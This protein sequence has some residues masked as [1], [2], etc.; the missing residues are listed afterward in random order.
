MGSEAVGEIRRAAVLGAG[1]MGAQIAAHL[2]NAGVPVW[3][4]D[5][6]AKDGDRTGIARRAIDGLAKLDPAPLAA[7]GLA[8]HIGAANYDEHL[9]R[10]AE[11]DLVIEAIA[12]RL[13]WKRELFARIA[14]HLAPHAILASNTSGLSISALAAGLPDELQSRFCGIHFFNP[15][16]YMH[17]VELIPAPASAPA[18]LDALETFLTTALGKG[19]IRAKDTPNFIANRIGVFSILA[20]F[21][22][23]HALGLGFDEIDALTG[24]RLGR[25]KSATFRTADVVGLDT[26]AH[27]IGTMQS[28]LPDDPWHAYFAAPEWLRGLIASGALGQKTRGGIY[29]KVGATITVLDPATGA[30]R[31]A[32]R[33]ID[34]DVA[35]ILKLRDPHARFAALRASPHPQARF[36]WAVTRDTLHYCAVQLE[37]IADNA[38]DLDLAVRW[39]FGW[40]DGP[41]ELWQAAGW[42]VVAGWIADDIAAGRA[43]TNVP[44]PAWVT[45]PGRDGVHAANGAFA[46]ADRVQRGRSTLPVYRRQAFPDR[47]FGEPAEFGTTLFE[48]DALR[49]WTTGDDI[50]VVSFKSKMHSIGEDVLDALGESIERAERDLEGLVIWQT[51]PPFS[52]GA[53]LSGPSA[54]RADR[55][56]PSGLASMWKKVRREAESA[57]LK[58]AHRLNVA[59]ALMAGRL[60]KVEGI[61]AHFQETTQ[62]L[63]YSRIPTVAAVDGMAL[64]GGCEFLMHCDRTVA[65][66]ESYI[67][68]VEVGVGLVPGGGG[69]KELVMRA[70][71]DAK[72]G[73]LFPFLRRYFESA[74][75]AKV[76]RSAFE[77]QAL[78][79]LRASD[80][81]VMHRFELLHVAKAELRALAARGYRPPLPSG[82]IPVGGRTARATFTAHLTNLLAGGHISEHDFRIGTTLAHVMTG[83]DVDA[84]SLVD[85]QW[86]LDL[87]REALI[88]LLATEQTQARIEHTLKT[89]KPLRN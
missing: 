54:P 25:P 28:G 16:R 12:E 65:T 34:P 2:V 46:P 26:L 56:K 57:I 36:L 17:L 58:A 84:G 55:P 60:E 66:L 81:V 53:N 19:V 18:M 52:V 4:F 67:G 24:T 45:E 33:D 85:E 73:D 51:E 9:D 43:M 62:A 35:G 71:A 7:P 49:L 42:R 21:H 70:A 64:G 8:A 75:T 20:A 29:R 30:H 44:L 86:L 40:K 41:F 63:R 5:L 82:A 61:V 80:P 13:D 23:A 27:V 79:F 83:G 39:G 10:L 3:L 38:R 59:D 87:E 32:D 78:G 77:A 6:P 74:A 68:L 1:V 47:V 48:T 31:T 72:G 14:P 50:G 69:C 22:H 11:C 37:H 89:G 76:S 15:P 88:G